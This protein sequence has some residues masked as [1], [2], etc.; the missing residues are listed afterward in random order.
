MHVCMRVVAYVQGGGVGAGVFLW[1]MVQDRRDRSSPLKTPATKYPALHNY[2][3]SQ[4]QSEQ[5]SQHTQ[6]KDAHPS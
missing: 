2:K 5:P 4:F 6:F 1:V 3:H